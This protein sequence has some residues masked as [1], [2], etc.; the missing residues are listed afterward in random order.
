MRTSSVLCASLVAVAALALTTNGAFAATTVRG[1]K[2]NSS[3]NVINLNDQAA[4]NACT[5][6]G[7]TV[8]KNSK[9]QDVCITPKKK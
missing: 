1:S 6:G 7:G 4:V 3:D 5:K 8:G 2:S 9:G